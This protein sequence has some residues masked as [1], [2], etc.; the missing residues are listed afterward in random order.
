MIRQQAAIDLQHSAEDDNHAYITE[1][2]I[3]DYLIANYYEPKKG[4]EA[5]TKAQRQKWE[6]TRK[7]VRESYAKHYASDGSTYVPP[8]LRTPPSA[9]TPPVKHD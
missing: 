9:R 2:Q 1:Q 5:R 8:Q 3:D 6:A 4:E 7:M